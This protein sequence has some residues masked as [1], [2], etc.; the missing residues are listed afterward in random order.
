MPPGHKLLVVNKV[1]V[2]QFE[3]EE[4]GSSDILNV[5]G[6]DPETPGYLRVDRVRGDIRDLGS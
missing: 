6:A 3:E 5:K 1:I 2:C 4:K